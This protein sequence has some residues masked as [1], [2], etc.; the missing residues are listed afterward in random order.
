[1][2]APSQ[3]TSE[4]PWKRFA[5]YLG[6]SRCRRLVSCIRCTVWQQTPRRDEPYVLIGHVRIYGRRGPGNCRADSAKTVPDRRT[7]R[8]RDQDA[9]CPFRKSLGSGFL[10]CASKRK[11]F[12]IFLKEVNGLH[13]FTHIYPGCNPIRYFLAQQGLQSTVDL[14]CSRQSAALG[15]SPRFA[16][17]RQLFQT[18]CVTA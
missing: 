16:V 7:A 2:A 15:L 12:H 9:R 18:S 10:K 17:G 11:N 6:A 14:R 8:R 1:M 4:A 5:A 3:P 13:S